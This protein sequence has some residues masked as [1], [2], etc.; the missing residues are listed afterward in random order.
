MFIDSTNKTILLLSDIHQDVRKAEYILS[1]ENY[2][3]AICLGDYFDS[4]WYDTKEHF[5]S[6]IDFVNRWS[7]K[8]NYYH[9]WGN[10]DLPYFYGKNPHTDG[11]GWS[12][13]RNKLINKTLGKDNISS[14]RN[15]FKWFL[16]VD[17]FL[18]T[19]AGLSYHWLPS[20]IKTGDIKISKEFI[21]EWLTKESQRSN[22]ILCNDGTYWT[23]RLGKARGGWEP[24]GGL[25]WLDFN[26]EFR[27]LPYI[28][29]IVG[30]TSHKSISPYH[31]DGNL[32][33]NDWENIDIDCHLNQ[34]LLITNKIV[35]VKN[36]SEL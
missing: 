36:Y 33:P 28:K 3:I 20:P 19:H 8:E 23:Y 25:I 34:Y 26:Y 10:H 31:L 5:L 35:S 17:D 6:T 2:D 13:S 7:K 1:K 22:E 15:S 27:P 18:C 29:Q 24:Y 30:H 12:K 14:I 4:T 11:Y 9:V 32:N 21:T 16:W